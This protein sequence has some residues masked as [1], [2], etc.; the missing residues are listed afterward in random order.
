MNDVEKVAEVLRKRRNFPPDSIGASDCLLDAAALL[1]SGVVVP[2]DHADDLAAKL[3]AAESTLAGL[4]RVHAETVERLVTAKA[5]ALREAA[6]EMHERFMS[7]KTLGT[8]SDLWL[9]ERA[10]QIER[11]VL[12]VPAPSDGECDCESMGGRF[13]MH[14]DECPAAPPWQKKPAPSDPPN[15]N[16]DGAA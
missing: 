12:A 1:A 3:A 4:R 8:A 10:D 7:G 15:T 16:K 11:A 14:R 2:A 6:D 5:T 9:R 13:G